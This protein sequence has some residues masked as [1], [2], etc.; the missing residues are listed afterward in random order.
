MTPRALRD[1]SMKGQGWTHRVANL[2]AHPYLK[3]YNN[4]TMQKHGEGATFTN[5]EQQFYFIKW[6]KVVEL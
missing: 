6:D 3:L 4:N 2:T 5:E 1:R